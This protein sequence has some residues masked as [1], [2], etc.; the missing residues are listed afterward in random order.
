MYKVVTMTVLGL[1]ILIAKGLKGK[2]ISEIDGTKQV[3]I[4]VRVYH[5]TKFV[6]GS[7]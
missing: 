4:W 6:H 1:G 2:I 3:V 5:E 7:L